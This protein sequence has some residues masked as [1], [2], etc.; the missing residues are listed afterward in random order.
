M[1]PFALEDL[2]LQPEHRSHTSAHRITNFLESL[3]YRFLVDT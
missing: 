3:S 2:V 1:T